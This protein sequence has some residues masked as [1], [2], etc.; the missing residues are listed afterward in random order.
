MNKQAGIKI[1]I[2]RELRKMS[3]MF[4]AKR[5]LAIS[6]LEL[7]SY[8]VLKANNRLFERQ[9]ITCCL[10]TGFII[11]GLSAKMVKT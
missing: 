5:G 9:R 1:I 3:D 7:F 2:L 4:S 10:N 6:N 11:D 8:D